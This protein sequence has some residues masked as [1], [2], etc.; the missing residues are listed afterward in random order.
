MREDRDDLLGGEDRIRFLHA[1]A[2]LSLRREEQ[3]RCAACARLGIN[4]GAAREAAQLSE[5]FLAI[6]RD[7]GLDLEAARTEPTRSRAASSP[8]FPTRSRC[9]ST[10]ARC[11]A[12]S[13]TAAAACSRARAWSSARASWSPRK[14]AK[15]NEQRQER[16]VLLTLATTIEE[17][18]LRELFPEAVQEKTEVDL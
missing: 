8:A 18:W 5:Q 1:H 14:F 10:R 7:E 15:S 6:A 4:A 17:E 16:Q 11:A 2:R 9:A 3:V 13:S 12:R